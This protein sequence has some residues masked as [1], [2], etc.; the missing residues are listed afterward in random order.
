MWSDD[1]WRIRRKEVRVYRVRSA[2][3]GCDHRH[4][5]HGMRGRPHLVL[6][7]PLTV[8]LLNFY[9]ILLRKKHFGPWGRLSFF[10]KPSLAYRIQSHSSCV[11][12]FFNYFQATLFDLTCRV[13]APDKFRDVPR[14]LDVLLSSTPVVGSKRS[15]SAPNVSSIR[16]RHEKDTDFTVAVRSLLANKTAQISFLNS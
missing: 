4:F 11:S 8:N 2:R 9:L 6:V 7:E 15:C 14:N 12:N 1:R 13:L 10:I 16:D 5:C 3:L